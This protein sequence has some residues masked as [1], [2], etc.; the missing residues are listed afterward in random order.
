MVRA[1]SE[2]NS[3]LLNPDLAAPRQ[4]CSGGTRADLPAYGDPPEY[5]RSRRRTR[6]SARAEIKLDLVR[7]TERSLPF[8]EHHPQKTRHVPT[9][10][11][12]GASG[13]RMSRH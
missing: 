5:L 9:T 10:A 4:Q 12:P 6:V 2:A 8:P 3:S 7:C 11:P 1:R 13:I